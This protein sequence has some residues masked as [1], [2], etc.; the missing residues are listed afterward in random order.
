MVLKAFSS[1]FG[2]QTR[3]QVLFAL[4]L[5]ASS[6]PSELAALLD[7]PA[8]GVRK[9][10]RSLELDGLVNG[11]SLGRTRVYQINPRY[12]AASELR[13]YLRKL[14]EAD[15]EIRERVARLRRRPRRSGKP[16]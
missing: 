5:L 7:S 11:R 4:E 6:Y 1:P 16:L 14:A 12:Y 10:L 9:A 2:G 15:S 8:S 3:T 13:Q